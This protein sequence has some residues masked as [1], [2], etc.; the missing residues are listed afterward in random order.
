MPSAEQQSSTL[1]NSI[2]TFKNGLPNSMLCY[3]DG[4]TLARK[5]SIYNAH[6]DKG[7][8]VN[9]CQQERLDPPTAAAS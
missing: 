3:T 4:E 7:K 9:L 5:M 6:W 1:C 2:L 8:N